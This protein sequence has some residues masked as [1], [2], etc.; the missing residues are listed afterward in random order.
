MAIK[1]LP[2][3]FTFDAGRL[4]RFEREARVL[5]SLNHPHIAAIYG[6][7]EG[8]AEA[9]PHTSP[10]P[11]IRALILELVEGDTLAERLA[12]AGSNG[13]PINDA[14]DIA[15]QIADALDAAHEKGIVHRDLKPA[16]IKI[17]PQGVVKVLDFG[18]AKLEA[19]RAGAAGE[20]GGD[21][22]SEA[23]TITVD[24][25]REG[26][27]VGTAAYMSPEQARGQA[28][29][30]RTDIWAFGCVLYEMLTGR[31]VYARATVTDTLAA[32]VEREPDWSRLPAATPST[33]RRLLER[34]LRKDQ[35]ERLRDIGD[36]R[37]ELSDALQALGAGRTRAS[38]ATRIAMAASVVAVF[39]AALGYLLYG[40]LSGSNRKTS[41]TV[42]AT[43][44]QLTSSPGVEWF[45][46]ISPDGK[47]VVFAGDTAGNRDIFLQSTT[48]Q[49][50]INLTA[51]S[52]DNDD[53]PAFSPDGERIAFRSERDGGGIFVMGRTGEAPR[54]I[55][56]AGYQPA[57]SPDGS[58]LAYTTQTININPQNGVGESEL[59]TADVVSGSAK[60]LGALANAVGVSWSPHGTRLAV[61]IQTS[62]ARQMDIVTVAFDTGQ[63]TPLVVDAG[64]DWSPLWSPDGRFVYFTSDRSGSMNLWR[65]PV[66]EQSGQA[67]GD[68]EPLTT[69]SSFASHASISADGRHIVYSSVLIT[70]NVARLRFNPEAGTT[71]GVLTDV[72]TGS[73][74]WA[75][76]DPSPDGEWVT[77]YSRQNPEG[78]IYIARSDGSGL[79][80]LT[81]DTFIDRVPR[82]SPDGQWI[83]FFSNRSGRP[84]VVWKI[85]RDG[86]ELMPATKAADTYPTWSPDGKRLAASDVSRDTQD[87]ATYVFDATV[88][89][90]QQQLETLPRFRSFVVNSWS[91]DG[92]MLVGQ[93]TLLPTGIAV[94]SF[95]DRTYDVLTDF[96]EFPVWLPDSRR[97]LFVSRGSEIILV[98]RVTK[99]R[100]TVFT[101]TRNV[102]GPPQITRDGRT[103][104]FS[105]RVTEADLWTVTLQ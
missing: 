45:P 83:A 94:Y 99:T 4:A 21:V 52:S 86:S 10:G 59:W 78:H 75:N 7:E 50:P 41:S 100:R 105:R 20:A 61:A 84:Y 54:R 6:I 14:L 72:T 33:V 31:A 76:P 80:Q 92:E 95:R 46:S 36:V 101:D 102:I 74:P 40:R 47:W 37:T 57:W 48:G 63:T 9:G 67:T 13:L 29:D 18:L 19:S 56:R 66:N 104:Y 73:R 30:K 11:P 43:F 12:R 79:R 26:L 44:N 42:R 64:Q 34:S 53:Q 82:W 81:S 8:P 90:A 71:E 97:V 15:R 23:P 16:N 65:V 69:P 77:F 98:D 32:L 38:R 1:I 58:T 87:P 39:I 3:A 89:V 55:T 22:V 27:I 88:P 103:V 85:R 68:P 60:R 35:R 17:T 28:V 24:D 91:P 5:A 62:G 51:D 70:S 96:G 93:T 49:N 2:R 25:T